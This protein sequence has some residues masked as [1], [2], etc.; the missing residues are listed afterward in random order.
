MGGVCSSAADDTP[1]PPP[2]APPAA[3]GQGGDAHDEDINNNSNNTS[4]PLPEDLLE[5][6][7]DP[8]FAQNKI[9]SSSARAGAAPLAPPPE[10]PAAEGHR[11]GADH[12]R[13]LGSPSIVS[14]YAAA[15]ADNN[16]SPPLLDLVERFPYLF[17]QKV[18]VHLDPIDRT[19]LAQTGRACRAVVAASSLPRAGT[20]EV[21]LG[22]RVWVV[23][24]KFTDLC[25][26]V[27]RLAWAKASGCPWAAR[28][29]AFVA[30]GGRLELLRWAREHDCPWDAWTCAAAAQGGHLE[31]LKWARAHGCPWTAYND[32]FCV[33]RWGW[34]YGSA[35]AGV[36]VYE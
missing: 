10:P 5:R 3:E 33:R 27:E 25:T 32:E 34:G 23:R 1:L 15:A 20:R 4:S 13:H 30:G 19:F 16:F 36:P 21:V 18:L 12:E 11:G 7:P 28:T 2:P 24:H 35:G 17:E 6:L 29:C 26:S 22:R 31:V 14:T 9:P 8:T